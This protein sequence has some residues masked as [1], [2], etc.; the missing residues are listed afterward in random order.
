[1]TSQTTNA[2]PRES[3][4]PSPSPRGR[5]GHTPG[6]D[7]VLNGG[8]SWVAR[9]RASEGLLPKIPANSAR[10][11]GEESKELE[12]REEDEENH[13]DS[14]PEPDPQLGSKATNQLAMQKPDK[15]ESGAALDVPAT[16]SVSNSPASTSASVG[17]PPGIVDLSS[18]EWSYL[19][20][21]GQVQGIL[22]DFLHTIQSYNKY[23]RSI[24]SKCN[25]EMGRRW[26]LF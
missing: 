10:D 9:R 19:D 8:E 4:M 7:G 1:M 17:L 26:F 13:L 21:Q 12:I 24:P 20:P 11:P 6:F 3:G 15:I 2:N 18:V 5:L 14:N 23:I 16:L 22:I 25:A